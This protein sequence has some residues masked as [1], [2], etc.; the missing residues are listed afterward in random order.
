MAPPPGAARH[1]KDTLR[2]IA[3]NRGLVRI[4]RPNST[5]RRPMPPHVLRS[6]FNLPGLAVACRLLLVA[7]ALVLAPLPARAE[8]NLTFGTYASDKPSAMVQ[9]IRPTLDIL[10]RSVGEILQ[11][12]VAIKME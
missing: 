12:K 4:L 6:Q 10:E 3:S 11:D 2:V 8:T 7:G 1:V 5:S 9:Q